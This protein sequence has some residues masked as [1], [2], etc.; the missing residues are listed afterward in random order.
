LLPNDLTP[1]APH[2]DVIRGVGCFAAYTLHP[3]SV[4]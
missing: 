4:S 2:F 1:T 3:P